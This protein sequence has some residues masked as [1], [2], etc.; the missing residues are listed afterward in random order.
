M[1]RDTRLFGGFV[2]LFALVNAYLLGRGVVAADWSGLGVIVAA[3]FTLA[4]YSF[5]YR[6]NPLFKFAEHVYVGVAAGYSFGQVWY[7]T[8]YGE[9]FAPV[10]GRASGVH[11][12]AWLLLPTGLGLLI[13]TRFSRRF[14]WLSRIAFAFIIGVGAGFTIPRYLS[15]YVLAQVEPSLAPLSWSGEGLDLLLILVGVLTVLVY[16][17]FSVEHTGVIGRASRV[18]IW[19]LMI[20]FG[21]SF[22]YTV[23]AR[24]S[25]LIGRMTFL[26]GDWLHLMR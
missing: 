5:L 22:G 19:F 12:D 2:L 10:L 25:L 13:L 16:F 8:L 15:S 9:I 14:G 21:A 3:G 11:F 4:L 18:G 26:L 23:M 6:D 17:F 24:L 1:N 7:T 20:S